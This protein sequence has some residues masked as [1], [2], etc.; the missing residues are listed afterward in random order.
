MELVFS[1]I[2]SYWAVCP[3]FGRWASDLFHLLGRKGIP[4]SSILRGALPITDF[5][6]LDIINGRNQFQLCIGTK[7][8]YE[9]RG[10]Y[11]PE[12]LGWET[13]VAKAYSGPGKG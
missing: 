8:Q 5:D 12:D 11:N 10:P 2:E 1:I 3:S 9:E 7:K 6:R 13:K 4:G